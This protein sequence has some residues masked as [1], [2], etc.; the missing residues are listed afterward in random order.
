[1]AK[2]ALLIGINYVNDPANRLNGCVN[3]IL[4]VNKLLKANGYKD[5]KIISDDTPLA[6]YTPSRTN[7]LA[8]LK[9][10]IN[11]AQVGDELFFH[12]SGHGSYTHDLNSDEPDGRDETICPTT[13]G[14]I[15]DDELKKILQKL[16]VGA[17]L[18]SL[19]D[20]CHSASV[21]DFKNNLDK[22]SSK[23]TTE[24]PHGYTV[25][26]SGC[27]D[28]QTSSDAWIA[29]SYQGAMTASY[30]QLV[31]EKGFTSVMSDLYSNSK[32]KLTKIRDSLYSWLQNNG[33]VQK[34]DISYEGVLPVGMPILS[35]FRSKTS[36]HSY[37]LRRTAA[38][39][40]RADAYLAVTKPN[41]SLGM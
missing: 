28:K 1:M 36:E 38:R 9:L 16:P 18:V 5:I 23:I 34:P 40:E 17:K 14:M 37:S 8:Q 22:P 32:A 3:D 31:K 15:T 26:V 7:I 11:S 19:M 2:R 35:A 21:F 41:I 4:A 13:G 25:M 24:I 33:F 39:E 20:C 30:L 10:L 29:E 6:K 27:Q 12:Y